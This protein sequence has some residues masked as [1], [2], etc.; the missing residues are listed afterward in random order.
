MDLSSFDSQIV[1]GGLTA[2]G[3]CFVYL[4]RRDT[5]PVTIT[6]FGLS[7]GQARS[8]LWREIRGMGFVRRGREGVFALDTGSDTFVFGSEQVEGAQAGDI[9]EALIR[10]ASL[11]AVARGEA[12]PGRRPRLRLGES[13]EEW[14]PSAEAS[15]AAAAEAMVGPAAETESPSLLQTSAAQKTLWGTLAASGLLLLKFGKVLLLSSAK[16]FPLA[17]KFIATGGTMLLAMALYAWQ[18]GWPFAIGF[19]FLIFVHEVGHALVMWRKGLGVSGIVFIPFFGAATAMKNQPRD[20]KMGAEVAI[21]GPA[22]GA[23]GGLVSYGLFLATQ[24]PVCGGV[25]AFTFVINLF[26]LVPMPPFDGGRIATALT[27]GLWIFGLVLLAAAVVATSSPFL[28]FLTVI[29]VFQ[30][31]SLWKARKTHP[32]WFQMAAGDR[33]LIGLGYFALTVF[34]AYLSVHASFAVGIDRLAGGK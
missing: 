25:A 8:L 3:L 14:R 26:N 27:P 19:I 23:F 4:L 7:L 33:W 2:L 13:C 18:T 5:P 24:S 21:A 10:G 22:A 29:G 32:A 15:L 16:L 1:L 6:E 20:A 28:L 31:V 17:W 30:A 12:S 34:L 9:K 11:E